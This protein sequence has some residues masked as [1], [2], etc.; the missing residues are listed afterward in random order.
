MIKTI[1]QTCDGCPSQWEIKLTDERMVYVRYRWGQL[2]I[3]ISEK[4]TDDI[5][6]AVNGKEIYKQVLSYGL[7]G[8][9]DEKE[10]LDHLAKV[11]PDVNK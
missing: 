1:T 8:F 2:S 4:E 5:Y 7:D 6:D 9:L 3:R 11:L 10:M